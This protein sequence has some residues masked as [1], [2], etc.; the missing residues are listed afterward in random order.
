MITSE[1]QIL[2]PMEPNHA[3]PDAESGRYEF[4]ENENLILSGL[5]SKM[6]LVGLF[7][8]GIGLFVFAYGVVRMVEVGYIFAGLLDFVVGIWTF[9]A[10]T[11]FK[12]I[13][14]TPNKDTELLMRGLENLLRL[15]TLVYWL[16]LLAILFTF[17]QVG[18]VSFGERPA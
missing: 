7:I 5:A 13:A 12:K 10:G 6:R 18:A 9:G 1:P 17:I 2:D 8:V 3:G 14:E 11:E 4:G 16:C 15:Y